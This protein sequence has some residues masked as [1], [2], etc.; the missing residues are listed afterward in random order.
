MDQVALLSLIL[1]IVLAVSASLLLRGQTAR[2]TGLEVTQLYV[3][4]VKGIRGCALNKARL[5]LFGFEGDRIFCLQKVIRNGDS[6]VKY[7][8]LLIGYELKLALFQA[9]IDYDKSLVTVKWNTSKSEDS[10]HFPLKPSLEGRSVIEASLHASNTKAYDMGDDLSGW[11]SD[12]IGHEVRLVYIGDGSRAVHGS[13][14]PHSSDALQKASFTQR[15]KNSI[16]FLAHKPERLTFSDIAHY[17]VVTEESNN[18]LSSRLKEGYSMDITKFRPN[19][20]LRGASGPFA[21]DYWGEL[22]FSDGVQMALTANCFRCQSITVDY[23]TGKTATGEQGTVW[24]KLNKDRRVDKGAKYSPV[25]GRYGF[26]YGDD[27]NKSLSIGQRVD[28]TQ[29][30]KQRTT[31]DWPQLST[32]GVSSKK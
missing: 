24:K 30:N 14:A 12:R 31:F 19:I 28:V 13:L 32:F 4:P 29:I 20:V 21:E 17:L 10:V 11:F 7:E 22:S 9:S 26:C 2:E 25:F 23:E 8:T 15:I 27:T 18:E 16:P 5:G 1:G 3:Y 6:N